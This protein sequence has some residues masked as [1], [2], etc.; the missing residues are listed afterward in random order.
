MNKKTI[1]F[2]SLL[3]GGLPLMGT[4][5]ADAAVRDTISINQGWQFHRGDV[6][7]IDELKT[8]Q[9][10]DDVVNLPHDFLIGQDWV[11]PDASERPDNSD[12]GSNVRSRLSPRGFKEMGIGWYRYQLTPKDEWKGKRIVLDFQGIMLVGDVYLNGKRIGGTD[13]GYLGFDIDL[14]K[15][16]K[17]GEANEITVKADTR[18]PNNSRW[19]TGAGLYRDVNLIIT[20]KNLF[21]PRH[22]LFIRTQDN[23]EVKIKA[24]I[25][26]QQKLAKGQ[27]KAV[28]P[29]E[30]RILDADG[31]VVA[32]QKNNIDF[33]AKWRDRE[34]EL[35]AI[36]L[37]NAQLWL[38]DTP[39]L[40]TAEVTLYDNEGNIA[41]QI[42]E[43][44]GV[45]TIEMN[46]EKGLLVNG[47]KVLLKGYA[48]HHTLG[49]L[50]AAAYPRAI[51]KRLKLMKEFGM[52]H[53]RTSHNPY[54]EDFLKLCDKYG[55]LVVDEL[56][57]KWLTQYA[58]GR[59]EWESL[60]QK[61][62][63]EW[64]KRDRN[65]PSVILWSLGNELQQYSNLPFNDWG[66][67][68]YKLQKE[69]L[70]R[71]D[72][73]RLT[74]VAMH[75]RYRNLETDSIPADLAVA[76]EVNSYNYRYMYF[77]GDMKRY[78][79]KT[80]YQSEASVAA[81]G[82]NFYEMDRDK[83]LGLAYWGTIDYLGES[84]GWPVKGWNQGVF[85]LSLQPKPDAYFVKS[86]FSEEP[87]VHIGIIEKSGGNIQWNGI[88]VSAGKLSEN[89]NREVGEKVSL[90]TYTNADEVELFLNGK[91]LGV[92]KNSEAPKLRARIKWDDIAYAPGVLLAVARKNGKVVARHQ[93]ETTGEAVALKLVP[94][95]ETW[96]ADGKDLMHVR[97]YAVDK[98]GRRV[99]N[100]KDAKAFDKLTFTVKG[101]A[102]IVAVDNGNIASDELHIGKT[103]LEKSIQ[104][105]LFQGSALVILRAGD[106]PG[107][108]E[109]SV[110]GEKMKAKK[111]V[112][113][114]K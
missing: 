72:D 24:E 86:M 93:I 90:Y 107:K 61:D 18:N 27:G 113:N 49:A 13:Y 101:D 102:N 2:A 7:N 48:N 114:T 56:Y 98:K 77:P 66:V 71:Y 55:I 65:H 99:L 39:Y 6:K 10:D 20:D 3:L 33:N 52:N 67:T 79:E 41:D 14:S 46:P 15:L 108:I 91:S 104:R 8:T 92:R 9:G 54:S 68:A 23:K 69:L 28:I 95:I 63:P 75:P 31:K 60:W 51:E 53:I 105:H 12:A 34:Y 100:V 4:L 84:M 81:M 35:P 112:L 70:H 16:L 36:S 26:N 80:F 88:N 74:T 83:V 62:I 22:P 85:D 44:F 82:P 21:F 45:R 73:T 30:V 103:Q 47:K 25:I 57:D 11:A 111:L 32:Q 37:E 42:K 78:P 50:G 109:L 29:V 96:H 43:P 89:W 1:L 64:V 87:V 38:P 58:G 5:S 19:F 40:Y 17:W 97:I 110:A 94:D 106:K 59:V 76:T